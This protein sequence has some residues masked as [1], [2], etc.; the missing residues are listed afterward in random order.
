MNL[1]FDIATNSGYILT[2]FAGISFHTI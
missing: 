1:S 2:L